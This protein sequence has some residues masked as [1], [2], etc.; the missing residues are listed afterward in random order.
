M[1]A[2]S[3][4]SRPLAERLADA[5][6][7]ATQFPGRVGVIVERSRRARSILPPLDRSKFLVPLDLTVGALMLVIRRRMALGPEQAL[8]MFVSGPRGKAVT[9]PSSAT[10]QELWSAYR[11]EDGFLL[12]TYA[13]EATFGGGR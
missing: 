5:E 11:G 3:F 2:S 13:A 4:R 8:F 7:I 6:R 9:P 1:S 12:M 10:M